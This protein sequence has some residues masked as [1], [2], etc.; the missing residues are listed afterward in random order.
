MKTTTTL[1]TTEIK[2]KLDTAFAE[3]TMDGREAQTTFTL[4]GNTL[5]QKQVAAKGPDATYVRT[6]TDAELTCVCEAGGV[7]S[8]RVYKRN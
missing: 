1:K 3:T 4:S 8:T 6:F 2:F 7:T 5:T